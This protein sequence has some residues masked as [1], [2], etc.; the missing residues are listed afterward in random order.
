M[1]IDRLIGIITILLQNDKTT[2]PELA[3]RFE[4]SR[5]TINRDIED[6]CKAG[7]PVITTQ[8][9]GGGLS[10][11]EGYKFDKTLFTKEELQA[12]FAGLR[13]MD[14]VSKGSALASLLDKLSDKGQRVIAEDMIIIDLASHYQTS[15]TQKI[16]ILKKAIW[17]K[18]IVS[19][20]YYYE[21]GE[22][23]RFIEP[24]RLIFKWSSWYVFGFCLDR[25]AYRLFKLNRLWDLQIDGETFLEREIPE[26]ELSF[27]DYLAESKFHL[28]AVFEKS[29]KHRLIEEYGID[30]Y[31]VCQDERLL[32]ERDFASYE[33]MR[34]WI[35]SF[36]DKVLI[37]A[38]KELLN[39]RK[40]QAENIIKMYAERTEDFAREYYDSQ[41][42]R[43]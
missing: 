42:K 37:L 18:H 16:D 21:K 38:P 2:A 36:G 17:T 14:S 12:V 26:E 4:V 9:Y 32:F 29:E 25:Q 27:G 3:E 15:L 10:I 40:K 11:A 33:N 19:F 31:L 35:F 20:Q 22:T 28:K 8:G 24:Y 6:I 41:N 5:R 1:K 43:K 34:E 30:S 7:I 23:K 13:G 39:D